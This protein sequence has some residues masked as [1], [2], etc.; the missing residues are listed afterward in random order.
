MYATGRGVPKDLTKAREYYKK[1]SDAG[2]AQGSYL[3]G[4]MFLKG[5]GGPKDP[6][7]ATEYFRVASKGGYARAS[8][9]LGEEYATGEGDVPKDYDKAREYLEE[10]IKTEDKEV[11]GEASWNLGLIYYKGYGVL[12]DK[13]KAAAY[14]KKSCDLGYE[15]ACTVLSE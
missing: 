7:K 15:R 6:D 11:A 4:T 1:A 9:I 10:A 3:L 14:V 8:L 12:V 13:N 5:E 2:I